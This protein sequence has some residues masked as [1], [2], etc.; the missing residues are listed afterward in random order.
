[1]STSTFPTPV[2]DRLDIVAPDA[3]RHLTTALAVK[4]A[5]ALVFGAVLLIWP[6][7]TVLAMVVLFGAFA[8]VEGIVG[9]WTGFTAT[10]PDR[11]WP[12]VAQG[13]LGLLTGIVALAWP[14]ATALVLLYLIG[15]WAVVK[16]V[17]EMTL[18]SLLHQA[19]RSWGWVATSG[20]IAVLFGLGVMINPGAGAL[21]VIGL[22]AALALLT[23]VAAIG[24]AIALHH[25]RA[26]SVR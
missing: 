20:V 7:P 13:T 6:A 3:G 19:D 25:R 26:E 17:T 12:V 15:I 16:G 1:M 14:G 11:K 22:I 10:P 4:G 2:L 18:A 24:G 21:A 9:I 8:I 23:G 5:L